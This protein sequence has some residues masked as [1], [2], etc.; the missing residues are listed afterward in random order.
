[1]EASALFKRGFRV[2]LFE[3][4]VPFFG[5]TVA[6]FDFVGGEEFFETIKSAADVGLEISVFTV[7]AEDAREFEPHESLDAVFGEAETEAVID[8]EVVHGFWRALVGGAEIP[9]VGA[10]EVGGGTATVLVHAT[11][12]VLGQGKSLLGRL[13]V[14]FERFVEVGGDTEAVLVKTGEVILGNGVALIGGELIPAGRLRGILARS[15]SKIIGVTKVA[16]RG[17]VAGFSFFADVS[18]FVLGVA[19]NEAEPETES[20]QDETAKNSGMHCLCF[21]W[22]SVPERVGA[23]KRGKPLVEG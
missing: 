6:A 14:K 4:F 18:E 21:P 5:H 8:S 9:F 3:C 1:M 17:F 22:R 10:S 23:G 13:G 19:G 16:L 11:E 2:P 7:L 20:E 12:A 15:L